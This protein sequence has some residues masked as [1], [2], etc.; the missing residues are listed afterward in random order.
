[1][2]G[3][4]QLLRVLLLPK[5]KAAGQARSCKLRIKYSSIC[6]LIG[7]HL[8]APSQASGQVAH[9]SNSNSKRQQ[10]LNC[11]P[12][13]APEARQRCDEVV[14][15]QLRATNQTTILDGGWRLV[16]TRDP[17]SGSET[18]SAMH[19]VD[20]ARSDANLAGLSLRC[21][22]GGV[23]LVL[24]VLSPLPRASTPRVTVTAAAD[25]SEFQASVIQIGDALLLPPAATDLA[26]GNWQKASELSIEIDT[27]TSPIRGVVPIGGLSA[28]LRSLTGYCPVK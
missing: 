17:G 16:K 26:G 19:T 11:V 23:Q 7:I 21:S 10:M 5:Y 3:S 12:G 1:M 9:D 24:I 25:R 8:G 4:Q 18:V 14:S 6:I 2:Q 13:A 22:P 15:D 28:A 27:K 20:I